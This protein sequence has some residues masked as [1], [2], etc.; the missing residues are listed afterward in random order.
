MKQII[1]T[2]RGNISPKDIKKLSKAGF[3]VIEVSNLKNIKIGIDD[4]NT[5]NKILIAAMKAI[6]SGI[7]A[8]AIRK[9]FQEKLTELISDKI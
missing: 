2:L 6:K 3:I 1:T 9:E 5:E 4:V 8:D 7:T